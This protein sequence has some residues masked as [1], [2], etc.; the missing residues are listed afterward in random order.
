MSQIMKRTNSNATRLVLF[1]VVL[2]PFLI[3]QAVGFNN[4]QLKPSTHDLEFDYSESYHLQGKSGWYESYTE[5]YSETGHYIVDFSGNTATVQATVDWSFKAY[6]EG[7]L[8][9][10]LSGHPV[11]SFTYSLLDGHYITGSDQDFNVTGL[12]VWFHVPGGFAKRAGSDLYQLA[13]GSTT[14]SVLDDDYSVGRLSSVWI[15][16]VI[17]GLGVALLST[18]SFVN[19]NYDNMAAEYTDTNYFT[20]EGFLVKDTYHEHGNGYVYGYSTSYELDWNTEVSIAS[21]PRETDWSTYFWVYWSVPIILAVLFWG[22]IEPVKRA[23]RIVRSHGTTLKVK[24]GMPEGMQ[25]EIETP[26]SGLLEAYVE[27]TRHAKGTLISAWNGTTI[28]GVGFVEKDKSSGTFF[29]DAEVVEAMVK[30]THVPLAFTDVTLPNSKVIEKY[31]VFKITGIQNKVHNTGA[32]LVKPIS[33]EY[34]ES[35]KKMIAEEDR[36]ISNASLA[37]WVDAALETDI[38]LVATI[39]RGDTFAAKSLSH[40]NAADLMPQSTGQ[41]ILAGI[42]FA[43]TSGRTG[44]LYGLYVHPA[45]RN[46]GIG[47]DLVNAR[48][49]ALNQI[50]I[51]EIITEIAE[52]NGPAK[53]IYAKMDSE[54]VGKIYLLSMATLAAKTKVTRH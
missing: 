25:F 18:G 5:D 19:T 35:A 21:W 11:Y 23:P 52:W 47:G 43:A 31:D 6:D 20:T 54:Q 7:Y 12:N 33:R 26:Y 32:S 49:S 22:I 42:G 38:C 27:R 37:N 53:A 13:N 8:D 51:T 2:A 50:G 29:G 34:I 16:Q 30:M 36:G 41:E 44:W 14:C 9:D 45:F 1:L 24:A 39:P 17:P 28:K 48:I 46:H 3:T 15:G 40:L 4:V 10:S